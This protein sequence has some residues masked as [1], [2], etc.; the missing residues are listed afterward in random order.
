MNKIINKF[1]LAGDKL[2]PRIHLGQ[3]GFTYSTWRPFTK[4]VKNTL[5]LKK[6]DLRYLSKRILQSFIS[7]WYGL[8][9]F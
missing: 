2:M 8:R 6:Q 3:P 7:A 5:N 4:N 1:L 9:R